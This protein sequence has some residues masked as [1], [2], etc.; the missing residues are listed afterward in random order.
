MFGRRAGLV[1]D[2]RRVFAEAAKLGKA[3][4]IDATPR[5]QD[6][7]LDLAR[8]ALAEGVEW[9]S[10][11]S[12]AHYVEELPNLPFGMAIAALA[13]IP[14]ERFLTYRPHEE[15]VAWAATLSA[16]DRA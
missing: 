6:L 13:G 1:A 12:D 2:W 11:G 8:L 4:E 10:M 14:R 15:V 5:R 16:G 7:P 3:L 9:F